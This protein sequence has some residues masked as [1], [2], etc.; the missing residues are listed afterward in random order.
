MGFKGSQWFEIGLP[1]VLLR[2][3]LLAV[4]KKIKILQ[5]VVKLHPDIPKRKR[6]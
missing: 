1:I 4:Q 3:N 6:E 2:S 5:K